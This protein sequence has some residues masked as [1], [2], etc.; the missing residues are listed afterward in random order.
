MPQSSLL[1]HLYPYFKGS[2]E[3]VA[4]NSL[5]YIISCSDILNIA[6]T[7]HISKTLEMPI[8]GRFQ[9]HCQAVGEN[10]ERPDIAGYDANGDERILCESKFYAALTVNQPNA[11]IKRLIEEK[12]IGLMFICPDIRKNGLWNE[13]LDRIDKDLSVKH[14]SEYCVE[15]NDSI[16]LGITTWNSILKELEQIA[17]TNVFNSVSDIRQLQGYCQQLDSEA[18]IPYQEEDMGIDNAIKAD[19]PYRLLDELFDVIINDTRYKSNRGTY[20][21]AAFRYGYRRYLEIEDFAVSLEYDIQKWKNCQSITTPFW[22]RIK[23]KKWEFDDQCKKAMLTIDN[24]LK[25]GEFIALIPQRY[26]ALGEVVEGM[27]K[28]IFNYIEIFKSISTESENNK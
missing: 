8:S 14:V 28:Q 11:Y 23:N 25:D 27:K 6:F 24:K 13:I 4:T 5:S 2:Q 10:K 15:I 21:P 16:R 20:N 9:Y 3:D 19:R 26:A 7:N 1:A 17:I 18:F 12:G 22:L